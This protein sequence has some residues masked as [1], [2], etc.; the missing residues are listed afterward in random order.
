MIFSFSGAGFMGIFYGGVSCY[1]H[2]YLKD[3]NNIFYGVSSGSVNALC[4]SCG[5][6]PK[7]SVNFFLN[8]VHSLSILGN[9]NL[10]NILY[11]VYDLFIKDH[12]IINK[13]YIGTTQITM[14]NIKEHILLLHKEPENSKEKLLASC[15]IP[16]FVS[17]FPIKIDNKYLY[18]GGIIN[19][20]C[21][22]NKNKEVITIHIQKNVTINPYYLYPYL[23]ILQA[24]KKK[25]I[26]KCIFYDGY[27]QSNEYFKKIKQPEN[28][29]QSLED[30]L[31]KNIHE[32]NETDYKDII[33]YKDIIRDM[34]Y[35]EM[36]ETNDTICNW[37]KLISIY[38]YYYF[39]ENITTI[40]LFISIYICYKIKLKK[41]YI[42]H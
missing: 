10:K 17:L 8:K 15:N 34:I 22:D 4:L 30:I 26:L 9:H 37:I 1:I 28:A 21:I 25:E 12:P 20:N 31:K 6:N 23:W 7:Y 16:F 24:P 3:K 13:C 39:L 42:L 19:P 18:D 33:F 11:N 40:T 29:C 41:K 5:I 2:N 14:C 35:L 27:I 38:Y 36:K 32:L